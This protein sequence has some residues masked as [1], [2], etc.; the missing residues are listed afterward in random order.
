[1][2]LA[3]LLGTL[4]EVSEGITQVV[5]VELIFATAVAAEEARTALVSGGAVG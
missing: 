1:M 4:G 2:K 3:E 5:D